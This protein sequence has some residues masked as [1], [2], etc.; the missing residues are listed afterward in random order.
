MQQP[1]VRSKKE[2]DVLLYF[3]AMTAYYISSLDANLI[4]A[5]NL[6]ED[7]DLTLLKKAETVG[8]SRKNE[9]CNKSQKPLETCRSPVLHYPSNLWVVFNNVG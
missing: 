6:S 8:K 9:D 5:R 4:K 2:C 1:L 7:A 3:I